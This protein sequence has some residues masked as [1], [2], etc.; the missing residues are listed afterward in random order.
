MHHRAM[1][2][3]MAYKDILLRAACRVGSSAELAQRLRVTRDRLRAWMRG[4]YA[5]PANIV[6]LALVILESRNDA[7]GIA[8]VDARK[9]AREAEDSADTARKSAGIPALRVRRQ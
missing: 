5:P 3:G 8:A 1:A 7:I 2:D 4:D 6:L 9:S